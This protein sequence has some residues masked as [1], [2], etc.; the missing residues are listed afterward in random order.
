MKKDTFLKK[1]PRKYTTENFP[2]KNGVSFSSLPSKVRLEIIIHV[3]ASIFFNL[4][5]IFF[6]IYFIFIDL[7]QGW[8]GIVAGLI[9]LSLILLAIKLKKWNSI[10]NTINW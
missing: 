1:F 9:L 6:G 4:F 3:T 2:V 7:L 10:L 5:L 8:V